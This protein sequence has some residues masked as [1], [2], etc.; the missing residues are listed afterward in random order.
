M[1]RLATLRGARRRRGDRPRPPRARARRAPRRRRTSPRGS[2]TT[3]SRRPGRRSR[4]ARPTSPSTRRRRD[5]ARAGARAARARADPARRSTATTAAARATRSSTTCSPTRCSRGS[6]RAAA[7]SA[8]ARRRERQHRR[9]LAVAV[10][11]LVALALSG[12]RGVRAG[13]AQPARGRR[14]GTRTRASSRR[15]RS[16]ARD[17]P[18]EP[19]SSVHAATIAR[20]RPRP[21]SARRCSPPASGPSSP[22]AGRSRRPYSPD[23]RRI[24]TAGTDGHAR[25]YDARTH[26]LLATLD[27]RL[28]ARGR[29]LRPVRPAAS[30]PRARTAPPGSGT[31]RPGRQLHVFRHR[32]AVLSAAFSQGGQPARHDRRRPDDPHLAPAERSLRARDPR[33]RAGARSGVRPRRQRGRDARHRSLCQALRDEGRNGCC[34]RSTREGR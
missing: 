28:A 12:G 23:G 27:A 5:G 15:P 1:L 2:S 14:R 7:A 30:S 9:L 21:S 10:G 3:S 34:A 16:R 22:R 33:A 8:S 29:R 17:D 20:P 6:G 11:S 32:G 31:P 24:P 25:L 26:R 13:P 4:T 19:L 18:A